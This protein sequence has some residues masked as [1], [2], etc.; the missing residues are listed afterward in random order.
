MNTKAAGTT[1]AAA[2][3]RSAEISGS[4]AEMMVA[5]AGDGNVVSVTPPAPKALR[6]LPA[7]PPDFV[8]RAD[9]LR[10]IVRDLDLAPAASTAG[11]VL[12]GINGMGGV[13]KTALALKLAHEL[14]ASY[15]DAQLFLDLRGVSDGALGVGPVAPAEALKHAIRSFRGLGTSLPDDLT[16][17]RP[18]YHSAIADYA[19]G[20]RRV[21]V[22]WDNARDADHV[23][24]LIP[25]HGCL[26][27]VTSRRAFTLE[28]MRPVSIGQLLPGD[29]AALLKSIVSRAGRA[30]SDSDAA[31]IA[32]LCGFLP[33]ALRLAGGALAMRAD[34]SPEALRQ[35]LADLDKRL[36]SLDSYHK[37][38]GE[39]SL[40]A[41]MEMTEAL[42]PKHLRR[43]W[44][45]L[46]VFPGG[47]DLA[48]AMAV[49]GFKSEDS[50]GARCLSDLIVYSAVEYDAVHKRYRLHDIVRSFML[51]VRSAHKHSQST[52]LVHRRFIEHYASVV[53]QS[54]AVFEANG[55]NVAGLAMFDSEWANI[56]EAVDL[57]AKRIDESW[58]HEA[59]MQLTGGSAQCL[60]LRLDPETRSKWYSLGLE[61]ATR[62]GYRPTICAMLGSLGMA[63]SELGRFREAIPYFEKNVE[64]ARGT[65]NLGSLVKALGGLALAHL[66]LGEFVEAVPRLWEVLGIVRILQRDTGN[67]E[68]RQLE[69]KTR[70]NLGDAFEQLGYGGRAMALHR[71]ALQICDELKEGPLAQA[72]VLEGI[73]RDYALMGETQEALAHFEKAA[74]LF[75][76]LKDERGEEG[77]R[78]NIG[79]AM[80]R[81]GKHREAVAYME[82]FVGLLS[83]IGHA[84]AAARRGT[85]EHVRA[86]GSV[87]A[88]RVQSWIPP[89]LEEPSIAAAIVSPRGR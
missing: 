81:I 27:L 73:G 60:S 68:W 88:R 69:G 80:A 13:G 31:S 32:Q 30:L 82:G 51:E 22:L 86:G 1:G 54:D 71:E 85:L 64:L 8:G 52:A 66:D 41:S 4:T 26:M 21:L 16:S 40:R 75:H 44:H 84:E 37:D 20:G 12:A 35:R 45:M 76:S 57:A 48:A 36:A 77:V 46:A 33:Q 79:L 5:I 18:I 67:R 63:K 10:D 61:A 38:S 42:L 87:E 56:Q 15:P 7:P 2:S 14:V 70:N 47:F 39:R 24:D 29:A 89:E 50:D 43:L 19:A 3:G 58:S 17:L 23:R 25:P 62:A 83:R 55:D 9:E 28:G 72:K 34:L 53:V 78:W 59:I 11:L 49:W 65:G 74:A 6:Q